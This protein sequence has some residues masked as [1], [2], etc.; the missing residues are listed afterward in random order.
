MLANHA[1]GSHSS[2]KTEKPIMESHHSRSFT[3]E[4]VSRMNAKAVAGTVTT[5]NPARNRKGTKIALV[6]IPGS[7]GCVVSG[8]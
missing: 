7:D 6:R 3:S 1:A 2:S 4:T 5:H 8:Q